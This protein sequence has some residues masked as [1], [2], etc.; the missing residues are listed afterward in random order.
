MTHIGLP[1]HVHVHVHLLAMHTGT[2]N[3]LPLACAGLQGTYLTDD[4]PDSQRSAAARTCSLCGYRAGE[5]AP[6]ARA[7]ASM[8]TLRGMQPVLADIGRHL[9]HDFKNQLTAM[10]ALAGAALLLPCA[11]CIPLAHV[12]M[13]GGSLLLLPGD[14]HSVPAAVPTKRGHGAV[15]A[16]FVLAS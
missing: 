1:G 16:L 7:Q 13:H 9:S 8:R 14:E 10:H 5:V 2:L 15:H 4:V 6:G 11:L 12:S 3:M